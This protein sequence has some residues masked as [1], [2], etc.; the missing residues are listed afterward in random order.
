MAIKSIVGLKLAL[1]FAAMAPTAGLAQ[2]PAEFYKG[3]NVIL[4]IGSGVGGG[5]DLLGR[6]FARH[7]GRHIPG[8][9]NIVVQNVPGGGSLALANQFANITPRDGTVFGIFNTGMATTPLFTP[10]VAKFDPRKF[11]F[12]GSPARE[13]HVLIASA[14]SPVKTLDDI[15][16]TEMIVAATAPG[17]GPFE[18]PLLTNTLLGT[19]FRIVTGYKS[20]NDAKLAIERGEVHGQAGH[21][22]TAVKS[23]YA[24]EL[25]N[26]SVIVVASFGMEKHADLMD[27]PL[28]PTGNTPEEKQLFNLMYARQVIGRPFLTP[29]DVP[30][31]RLKALRDAWMAT[32]KDPA[33]LAEAKKLDV[34]IDPVTFQ[35]L[36]K[37]IADLY[38]TPPAIIKRMQDILA[39]AKK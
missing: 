20:S 12:I 15:F 29:P 16:K 37:L 17:A 28:M 32:V 4:Q 10:E 1:A 3:K 24:G 8:N 39:S 14:K 30:A 19:K 25:A 38:A 7:I 33:F 36:D 9:P 21:G 23:E 27:V 18:F 35:E 11:N 26:K 2:T 31:D 13:A 6:L 22:W 34:D 5:Y